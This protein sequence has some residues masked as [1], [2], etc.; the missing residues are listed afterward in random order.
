MRPL[1]PE[2][3]SRLELLQKRHP[4]LNDLLIRLVIRCTAVKKAVEDGA[5]GMERSAEYE[6]IRGVAEVLEAVNSRYS[7]T[8]PPPEL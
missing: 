8:C 1:T 7:Q 6:M 5:V 2:E 4:A 3:K